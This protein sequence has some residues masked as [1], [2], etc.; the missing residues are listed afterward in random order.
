LV[1]H[2]HAEQRLTAQD[3]SGLRLRGGQLA[4]LSA[5]DTARTSGNL[6]DEA[7]HLASS[8]QIAGYPHVVATLW[9][10]GEK[11]ATVAKMV[12]DT[13]A[14][15][16]CIATAVHHTTRELRRSSFNEPWWWGTHIRIGP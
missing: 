16:N 13:L 8:F 1:L 15:R 12:Y 4:F 14:K 9:P 11:A 2:D 7:I 5:C 6:A 3:I 10:V